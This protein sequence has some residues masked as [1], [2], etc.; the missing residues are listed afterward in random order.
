MLKPKAIQQVLKQATSGGVRATLLLNSEGSPISFVAETDREARI[1]AA[2]AS[3]VWTTFEKGTKSM[4]Q[5]DGVRFL[6][7]ECEEGTL[8]LTT[9]SKMMLCLV[10]KPEVGI[11]ILKAKSDA[12]VRHLEEP[13]TNVMTN[14]S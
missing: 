3:N 7:V 5:D 2:I 11:A 12:L 6:V 1:Y 10:A 14:V 9:V 4:T 13:L 8:A